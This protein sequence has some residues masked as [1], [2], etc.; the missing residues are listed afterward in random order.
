[1]QYEIGFID[2]ENFIQLIHSHTVKTV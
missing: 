1:M 2:T